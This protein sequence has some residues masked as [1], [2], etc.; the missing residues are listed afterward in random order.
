MHLIYESGVGLD[1]AGCLKRLSRYSIE[2]HGPRELKGRS[3]LVQVACRRSLSAF[4]VTE[5]AA[6][7]LK[8]QE[9][10]TE[11]V[12]MRLCRCISRSE[13]TDDEKQA[14]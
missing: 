1:L 10:K 2:S 5:G 12:H 14:L 13:N 9:I 4:D 7:G 6:V 8:H 11:V 3:W